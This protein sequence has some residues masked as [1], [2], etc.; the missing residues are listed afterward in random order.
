MTK[1]A[2]KDPIW[3]GWIMMIHSYLS[4]NE[5]LGKNN[6]IASKLEVHGEEF[7]AKKTMTICGFLWPK[8]SLAL[9]DQCFSNGLHR[10]TNVL[11]VSSQCVNK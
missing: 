3:N 9:I 11:Y 2:S 1:H 6:N 8:F 10:N 7:P 4:E 5:S